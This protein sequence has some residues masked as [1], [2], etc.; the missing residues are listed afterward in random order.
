VTAIEGPCLSLLL[1]R[2]GEIIT[3]WQHTAVVL[4][5]DV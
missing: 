4:R 3:A 2:E 1:K 5:P